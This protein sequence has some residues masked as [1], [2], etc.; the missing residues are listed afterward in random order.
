MNLDKDLLIS[1]IV[2]DGQIVLPKGSTVVKAN[3]ILYIL[4]PS[5]KV[6]ELAVKLNG[7]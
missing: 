2:R 7:V 4:A 1:S 6:N 3:D 5:A